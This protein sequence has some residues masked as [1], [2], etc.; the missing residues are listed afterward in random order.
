[1]SV[2]I[3]SNAN[4]F[5]C[6][7]ETAYGNVP[8]ITAANRFPAVKL[9][10]RQQLE[11]TERKDKTGTR[12]FPGLPPGGRRR[13]TFELTTYMTTSGGPAQQPAYGPLFHA[14][15]GA[16]PLMFPGGTAGNSSGSTL[17]FSAAHGL[18]AG[19]A[20]S[21]AGEIRFVAAIIDSSSVHLNAPFSVAPAAGSAIDGTVTYFP[22]TELPSASIFDYWTP[23]SAVHRILCGAAV[24]K[25]TIEINGDFH[26]FEFSGIA[27]DLID[28]T[29]FSGG[30]GQLTSFP[31]EPGLGAFDYSIIPGHM[32]QVWLGN[33]PDRFYTLTAGAV[34]LNN[35][36]EQRDNEFGSALPRAISPGVRN[37]S[38]NFD[39]YQQ[40][41]AATAGLYQ[42]ARQQ[43]PIPLMFQL[44]QQTGQLFGVYLKGLMPEVPEFDDGDNRLRWNF[45]NSR[46]QGTVDDEIAV[47]FA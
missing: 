28:S 16:P 33:T 47:A 26:Q 8:G 31:E 9:K 10:A 29:S 24:D 15:L 3:S 45:R 35:D 11:V 4:R 42:A 21:Y 43:S 38:A 1:M 22:G 12:T 23:G 20:V 7:G 27:Q 5:Y 34:V 39:L 6:A 41:D 40:D 17:A 14:S 36:L 18:A 44:G 46:A 32:G 2:Y 13:S 30:F 19:Q 25:M 37:V